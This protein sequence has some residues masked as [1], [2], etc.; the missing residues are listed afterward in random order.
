MLR[1]LVCRRT[2][3]SGASPAPVEKGVL[4]PL[5]EVTRFITE[6]MTKVGTPPGHAQQLAQVLIAADY[7]GHFSHGLNRLGT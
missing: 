5:G 1:Q 7:R 4:I 2:F 3:S 6:C